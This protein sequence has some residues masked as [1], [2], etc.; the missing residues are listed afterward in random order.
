MDSEPGH[1]VGGRRRCETNVLKA[2][3][4]RRTASENRA[5]KP[6]KGWVLF[7]CGSRKAGNTKRRVVKSIQFRTRRGEKNPKQTGIT[8]LPVRAAV[9][10]R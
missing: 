2:A 9:A 1:G 8:A 5:F 4:A 6:T 3:L 10:A 7:R